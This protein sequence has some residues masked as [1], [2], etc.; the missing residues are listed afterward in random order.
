[1]QERKS[2]ARRDFMFSKIKFAGQGGFQMTIPSS[3]IKI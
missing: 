1:M 2:L 3:V